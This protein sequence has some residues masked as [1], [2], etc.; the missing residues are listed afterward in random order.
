MRR[1][2]AALLCGVASVALAA[3]KTF[4][5]EAELIQWFTY[6]YQ[7]PEPAAVADGMVEASRRGLFRNGSNAPSFFGFLAGALVK[8]PS[9][10][11]DTV[12]R[13]ARLPENDQPIVVFG[14]WYSGHPDTKQL[15][16]AVGRD[17]PSQRQAV[18][19]LLS[20]TAPR[21]TE[22]PLK[23]GAWVL[24]ALWGNFIATGDEAPILRIISALPWS[25]RRG[26]AQRMVVGGAARWS[27][28]AN[29]GLHPRVLEICRQQLRTQPKEV[30]VVLADV[31]RNAETELKQK[32]QPS[33]PRKGG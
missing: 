22:I 25:Q 10:A 8:A 15:L 14:L 17:M 12:K 23:Q 32:Q 16:A 5:S 30:A 20:S 24:D 27:L 4:S 29:A 9:T 2:A 21:L 11:A 1:L 19:Q 33:P 18:E 13:M 28:T 26:D 7:R 31:I 3:P 6:Y